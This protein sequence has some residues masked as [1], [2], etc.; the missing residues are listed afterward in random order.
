MNP[1]NL[2]RFLDAF[3]CHIISKLQ[4]LS[5]LAYSPSHPT[6]IKEIRATH[7]NQKHKIPRRAVKPHKSYQTTD[8]LG[9]YKGADR[10]NYSKT[11]AEKILEIFFKKCRYLTA[12]HLFE[13]YASNAIFA[14]CLLQ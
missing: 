13:L 5:C 7:K 10:G 1:K 8:L 11:S 3:E 4:A 9:G 12:N 6:L 2:A 14:Q